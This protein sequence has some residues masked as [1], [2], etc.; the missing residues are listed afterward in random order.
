MDQVSH[1]TGFYIYA[2]VTIFAEKSY[3]C[4]LNEILTSPFGLL[5]M[6]TWRTFG[7]L[8]MTVLEI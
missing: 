5:R 2:K 7:L 8:R 1:D 3:L 4:A 6:T